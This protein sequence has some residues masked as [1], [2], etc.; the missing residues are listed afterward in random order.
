[1]VGIEQSRIIGRLETDLAHSQYGIS[2]IGKLEATVV[3]GC[4]E[5]KVASVLIDGTACTYPC[6]HGQSPAR[7]SSS[8]LADSQEYV[9]SR[10]SIRQLVLIPRQA[11]TQ[12]LMRLMEVDVG[13][14][15]DSASH[16][17]QLF[18][19]RESGNCDDSL[20]I[21][22]RMYQYGIIARGGQ[23]DIFVGETQ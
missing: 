14:A 6:G 10:I 5:D 12:L 7:L 17:C 1:M 18:A 20:N 11:E 8:V 21:F 13:V 16:R 19:H 22:L 9:G 15:T 23:S 3:V 4:L 2:H